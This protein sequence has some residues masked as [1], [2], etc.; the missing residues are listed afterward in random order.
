[1]SSLNALKR[2]L[3]ASSVVLGVCSTPAMAEQG[4]KCKQV[5]INFLVAPEATP[6]LLEMLRRETGAT[7]IRVE[8]PGKGY[9]KEHN[10]DRLRV[11]VDGNNLMQSFMCG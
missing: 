11:I 1:M 7:E 4:G 6:A 3:V 2:L 10:A 8:E 5:A 9:T